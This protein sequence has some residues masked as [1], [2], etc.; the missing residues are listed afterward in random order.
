[1]KVT[2]FSPIQIISNLILTRKGM[3]I[4]IPISINSQKMSN[5]LIQ[6]ALRRVQLS[7]EEKTMV[8]FKICTIT[9]ITTPT[10]TPALITQPQCLIII[11]TI[12]INI[13]PMPTLYITIT[14]IMIPVVLKNHAIISIMAIAMTI[15]IHTIQPITTQFLTIIQILIH[16]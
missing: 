3:L 9:I 8:E 6:R 1:M 14:T 11:S 2:R 5:S 10:I 13:V 7:L 12:T 16:I 15:A 4:R